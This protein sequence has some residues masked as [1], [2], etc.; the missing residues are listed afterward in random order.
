[1]ILSN[2][3]IHE[4]LDRGLLKITPEPAPRTPSLEQPDCPYNTSSVDLRLGS[5][6]AIPKTGSYSYDLRKGG[7]AQFLA[8]NSE[9]IELDERR[10]YVLD[11]NQFV[12][13]QTLEQIE[14]PLDKGEPVLAA[15]IEGRSSFARC[16]LL[17]HFTAPT[18]HAGFRG[19]LTLEMR[20]LGPASIVLFSGMPICQLIIE[21]V[22]GVP[23]ANPSQFQGQKTPS[24]R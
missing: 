11:L 4:A 14:L 22:M 16:G 13:G 18:V 20:N 6:L 19:T 7:I 21:Q 17:V 9:H 10:P 12:L 24:G 3:A 2:A 5:R 1:M 15:R 8:D 23:V